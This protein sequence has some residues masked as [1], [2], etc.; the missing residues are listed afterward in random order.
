MK[1]QVTAVLLGI[2]L[3]VG[4][5]TIQPKQAEANMVGEALWAIGKWVAI[6]ELTDYAKSRA[7][8]YASEA[9]RDAVEFKNDVCDIPGDLY[10]YFNATS[11]SGPGPAGW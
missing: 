6:D 7:Y 3:A 1:R 2:F 11:G 9:Y 4:V 5:V 10:D 8:E